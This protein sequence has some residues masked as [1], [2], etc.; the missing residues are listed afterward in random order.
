MNRKKKK[1][2][3][4]CRGSKI[5]DSSLSGKY[6]LFT[7]SFPLENVRVYRQ[8]DFD[9]RRRHVSSEFVDFDFISS[10]KSRVL[11]SENSG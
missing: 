2:K 3:E 5:S 1:K 9:F 7:I 6:D 8:W 11:E 10:G 4:V